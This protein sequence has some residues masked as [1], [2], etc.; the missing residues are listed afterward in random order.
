MN[1][2]MLQSIINPSVLISRFEIEHILHGHSPLPPKPLNTL[3][4]NYEFFLRTM[5]IV[6]SRISFLVLILPLPIM[7]NNG[8]STTFRN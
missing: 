6:L 2:T 1:V 8:M 7:P 4:F 3:F 5:F